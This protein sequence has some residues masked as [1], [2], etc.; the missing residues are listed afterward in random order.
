M[1]PPDTAMYYC[2]SVL[3]QWLRSSMS[4]VTT[5]TVQCI[6]QEEHVPGSSYHNTVVP[7]TFCKLSVLKFLKDP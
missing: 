3:R 2:I 4:A 7:L 5:W 1:L 6:T